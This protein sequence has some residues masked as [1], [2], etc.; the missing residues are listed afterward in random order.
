MQPILDWG[1]QVILWLQQ[2]SP[3]LD[4][5]FKALSRTG[6]TAFY[7]LFL[8]IMLWV[9][10]RR[11][12]VRLALVFLISALVNAV[13]K[14]IVAQPRPFEYDARVIAL[15]S[16]TSGGLPSGHTQNAVVVWGYL[17]L[18]WRKRW[19]TA[20]AACLMILVPLSRVYLGVHFPTDLLGGYLLGA[21]VLWLFRR[22][23]ERAAPRWNGLPLGLQMA[24]G[25]ALPL[26][27]LAVY[28]ALDED[29][30][31]VMAALLGM[32][33]SLPLARRSVRFGT[34]ASWRQR[35]LCLLIG[36]VGVA[37]IYVGL[38]AAL[39]EWAALPGL[40]AARYAALGVWVILGAPWLF[41]R[42]G[43]AP[44]DSSEGLDSANRTQT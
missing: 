34:A 41:V 27:V 16:A 42:L 44:Q 3:A 22:S 36:M 4:G 11:V 24:L 6:D 29:L 2:F 10:D 12:A 15:V 14:L 33:V 37:L 30:S 21:A 38:K 18:A 9:V 17:A 35:A 26:L 7:V 40:R 25:G 31:R 5:P 43:L 13:A 28:P 20:L 23:E 1:V 39:G 32:A 8:P 19:L